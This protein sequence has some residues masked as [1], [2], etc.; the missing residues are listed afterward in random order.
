M[1]TKI[2]LCLMCLH[3]SVNYVTH[4]HHPLVRELLRSGAL[5][6][7]VDLKNLKENVNFTEI[8]S[9]QNKDVVVSDLG[10]QIMKVAGNLPVS[11]GKY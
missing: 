5:Q 11:T 4:A 7:A 3:L 2:F 10:N 1:I 8:F 9:S 6:K